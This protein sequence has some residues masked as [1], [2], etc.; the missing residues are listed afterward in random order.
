MRDKGRFTCHPEYY[1]DYAKFQFQEIFKK[2]EKFSK[3][4]VFLSQ[5]KFI[6]TAINFSMS[7]E[8]LRK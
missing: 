6:I 4:L 7:S 2:N 8:Q 3:L 5:K 1:D